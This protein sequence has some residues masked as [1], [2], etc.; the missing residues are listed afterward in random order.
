MIQ[1]ATN[2]PPKGCRETLLP[3]GILVARLHYSADPEKNEDWARVQRQRSIDQFHS[4]LWW[5][6]EMEIDANAALGAPLFPEFNREFTVCKPFPIP[7]EW[8]RWMGIDPHPRVPHAMLW[9][10]VSPNDDWIFYREY[11]P[12]K[13]Y[14]RRGDVPEDDNLPH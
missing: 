7:H 8:T 2:P 9:L 14:G 13:I 12:S 1:A 3:N 4:D 10:A 5:R 6:Q 11:W